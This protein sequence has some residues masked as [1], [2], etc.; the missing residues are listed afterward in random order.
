MILGCRDEAVG[1]IQIERK[2]NIKVFFYSHNM[3]GGFILSEPSEH[4]MECTPDFLSE[5]WEIDVFN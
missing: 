3:E 4:R 5:E 2:T 1:R